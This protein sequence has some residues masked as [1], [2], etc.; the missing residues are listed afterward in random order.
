MTDPGDIPIASA[1][2]VFRE[3][4]DD[5]GLLFDPDT[6]NV[7]GLNPVAVFIWK[8]IDGHR[9]VREI[10]ALVE[11]SFEEVPDTVER[12]TIAYIDKLKEKGFVGREVA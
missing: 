12:D 2:A 9:S 8:H 1:N 6:G 4:L 5:W 7:H 3:E 11:T 10:A